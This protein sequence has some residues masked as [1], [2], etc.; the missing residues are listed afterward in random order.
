MVDRW[1]AGRGVFRHRPSRLLAAV[2]AA[3]LIGIT[4]C[5]SSSPAGTTSAAAPASTSASATKAPVDVTL[6]ETVVNITNLP[7]W[8]ASQNGYFKQHGLNV[9]PV[10]LTT[11]SVV[12]A[13]VAGS[14]QFIQVPAFVYVQSSKQGAAITAIAKLDTGL[15]FAMAISNSFAHKYGITS[16]TPLPQVLAHIAGSTGGS[17]AAGQVGAAKIMFQSFGLNPKYRSATFSTVPAMVTALG[18]NQIDWLVVAQPIPAQ[19][20][21]A[22][23]GIVVA[24]SKNVKAWSVDPADQMLVTSNSY[25]KAHPSVA[26]AMVAA[27]GEGMAFVTQHPQQSIA[28]AS[29]N[30]SNISKADIKTAIDALHWPTSGQMSTAFWN[31]SLQYFL[32]AGILKKAVSVSALTWTNQFQP[33]AHS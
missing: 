2:I 30:E 20:Q 23:N 29:K 5:G 14:A 11:S 9:K 24:T 7:I 28:I 13:L 3:G 8:I 26:K 22:G 15:P 12:P 31:M 19:I 21:A 4:G 16:S 33:A 32:R 18:R 17:T 1:H 10:V 27:L 25:A 6:A